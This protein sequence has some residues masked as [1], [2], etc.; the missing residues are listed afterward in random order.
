MSRWRCS[1]VWVSLI[2][3]MCSVRGWGRR[4]WLSCYLCNLCG[5]KLLVKH[6]ISNQSAETPLY[7]SR[8]IMYIYLSET[9]HKSFNYLCD[10]GKCGS[11]KKSDDQLE[12][13]VGM[14][15]IPLPSGLRPSDSSMRSYIKKYWDFARGY[16]LPA[17]K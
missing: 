7:I 2:Y 13:L 1:K 6:Y 4:T 17:T 14:C 9:L 3:F 5:D 16:T 12:S 15:G 10:S 11:T 8:E